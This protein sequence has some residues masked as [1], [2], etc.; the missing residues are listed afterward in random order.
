MSEESINNKENQMKGTSLNKC[1][2]ECE[3][4]EEVIVIRVN[5]GRNAKTRLANLGVVP[6]VKITKTKNAPFKGPLE[7]IVKGSSLVIGRGLASK[8]IVKCNEACL[9]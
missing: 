9:T 1:L 6:G 7:I 3:K 5:A 8:I 2:T 4:G